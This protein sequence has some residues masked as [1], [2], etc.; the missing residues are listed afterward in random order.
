MVQGIFKKSHEFR[1]SGFKVRMINKPH[2]GS[3]TRAIVM[4]HKTAMI[5]EIIEITAFVLNS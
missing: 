2:I 4:P 1:I 3:N 5:F